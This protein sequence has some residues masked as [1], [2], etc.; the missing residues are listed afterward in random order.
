MHRYSGRC[1]ESLQLKVIAEGVETKEQLD[2][3]ATLQC[4][5]YQGYYFGRPGPAESVIK[6]LQQ[7][8]HRLIAA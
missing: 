1:C 8:G 7:C 5:E 4:D 3:L 2:F 6:Y